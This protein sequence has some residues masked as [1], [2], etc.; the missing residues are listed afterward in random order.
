MRS[1]EIPGEAIRSA[2][3]SFGILGHRADDLVV[4]DRGSRRRS[5]ALGR[6]VCLCV[7]STASAASGTPDL[8]TTPAL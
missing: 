6:V 2:R 5:G 4:S 3:F 8:G 7:G 1:A